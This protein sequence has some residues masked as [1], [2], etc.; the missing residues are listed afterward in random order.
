[1]YPRNLFLFLILGLSQL[2]LSAQ[3]FPKLGNDTLLDIATWN[4]E[5]LGDAS[6]GPDDEEYQ[7]NNVKALIER[8]DFDIVALQEVSNV[9]TYNTLSNLLASKYNTYV[10]TFSASQ[11][12]ALYWR[13][14]MFEVVGFET[15]HILSSENYVFASRPPLQVCLKTVGGTK[16]DTLYFIVLH[17][18]ANSDMESYNRRKSASAL[19][20]TYVETE[21]KDKKFVILGDWNDDL[22]ASTYQSSETPFK[23]FLDAKYTYPSKELTDAGKSSYAFSS[24]MLDHI[25]NAKIL[26]S[27]YYKNSAR[28]F[29]NA[30]TYA[31]NFSQGVSDHWPVYAF[32]NWKKLTTYTPP[33][34][35]LT[36]SQS[37]EVKIWPNPFNEQV[38][39]QLNQPIFKIELFNLTGELVLEAYSSTHS[40]TINTENQ[41]SGSYII[42]INQDGNSYFTRLIK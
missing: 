21:L 7:L 24:T 40:I 3:I 23:N 9:G 26:D 5:W 32:Y 14:N 17:L 35:V 33:V 18:K 16:V 41:S 1:M 8:T 30:G 38:S 4:T 36:Y 37:M 27:F 42:R 31:D 2:T 19:L 12:M 15:K 13:K 29:D 22:D 34:G 20:K 6:N 28:V 10:S 25:L 11:K 39:I